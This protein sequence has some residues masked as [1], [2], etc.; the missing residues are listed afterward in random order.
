MASP[1]DIPFQTQLDWL[2]KELQGPEKATL[3]AFNSGQYITPQEYAKVFET[4]LNALVA[5]IWIGEKPM[6]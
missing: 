4:C 3:D 2:W 6:H 5:N 1:Y